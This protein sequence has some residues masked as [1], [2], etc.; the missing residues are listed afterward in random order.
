[1]LHIAVRAIDLDD[2]TFLFSVHKLCSFVSDSSLEN[3]YHNV[4]PGIDDAL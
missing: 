4:N 1:M 3:V 2:Y